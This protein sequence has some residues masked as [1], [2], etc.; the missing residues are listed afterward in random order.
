MWCWAWNLAHDTLVPLLWTKY[1]QGC[2][3]VLGTWV[4]VADLLWRMSCAL[5]HYVCEP[6]N[7]WKFLQRCKCLAS[8]EKIGVSTWN[9]H[10]M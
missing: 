9:S 7:S 6:R 8:S 3:C 10:P 4:Q 5:E 1:F 2:S